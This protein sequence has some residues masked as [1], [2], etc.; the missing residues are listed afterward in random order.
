MPSRP[1]RRPH[2]FLPLRLAGS[3]LT[4]PSRILEPAL[5]MIRLRHNTRYNQPIP[6]TI[7]SHKCQISRRNMTQVLFAHILHHH[8]NSH[9]HRGPKRT[10]HTR[11]Q[12][13]QL[14]H[15]HWSHKIKV[16]HRSRDRNRPCMPA[17]SH[18]ANQVDVLHQPSAKQVPKRIRV[19][20]KH[21][22]TSLRLRLSHRPF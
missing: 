8:S 9:L 1:K 18:C 17:G 13:Q 3:H 4:S 11:L 21:N 6:F 14:P 16:I 5:L 2:L 15:P 10:I 19:R 12:D 20:R 22:L 7:H